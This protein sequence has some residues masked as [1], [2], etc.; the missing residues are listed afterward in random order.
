MLQE[1][2]TLKLPRSAFDD[3][4]RIDQSILSKYTCMREWDYFGTLDYDSSKCLDGK[5]SYNPSQNRSLFIVDV[6]LSVNDS[7]IEFRWER[8]SDRTNLLR[9]MFCSHGN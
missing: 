9:E 6:C 7:F 3:N 2:H 4:A 5:R 1:S 8:S